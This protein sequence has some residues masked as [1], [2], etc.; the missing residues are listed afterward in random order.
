MWSILSRRAALAAA[1]LFVSLVL[2][3]PVFAQG[4]VQLPRTVFDLDESYGDNGKLD[5]KGEK[6][7]GISS[8]DLPGGQQGILL[9]LPESYLLARYEL[10]AVAS[11]PQ[12]IMGRFGKKVRCRVDW[13][14]TNTSPGPLQPQITG[15]QSGIPELDQAIAA[16]LPLA[17]G[18]AAAAHQER[19]HNK[20]CKLRMHKIPG[21]VFNPQTPDLTI[22]ELAD[23][24][25][26]DCLTLDRP[27]A[28]LLV[29]YFEVDLDNP[30]GVNTL[31]SV[32][33]ADEGCTLTRVTLWTDLAVPTLS[34]YLYLSPNDVQTL[35]LRDLFN[36]HLPDT[37]S[38]LGDLSCP[39]LDFDPCT[40]AQ[41]DTE[42]V[43]LEL[44]SLAAA[45]RGAADPQSGTC[46]SVDHGDRL[47]RGYLTADV[48]ERC[49]HDPTVATWSVSE[50]QAP[51]GYHAATATGTRNALWGDYFLV[52]EAN[53][54]AQSEAAVPV[55]A[56]PGRFEPGDYTFYG[57]Y[58]GFDGSDAHRPLSG[59]QGIRFLQGG[60]FDGGTELL[61]WRD[62]RSPEVAPVA[63]GELPDWAPLAQ[64][65]IGLFDED[66]L[67]YQAP[68]GSVFPWATQ[69]VAVGG[70]DFPSPVPFGWL[71]L[72][73]WHDPETPAQAWVTAVV[74]ARGRFSVQHRAT[75]LDDLCA[76]PATA[77]EAP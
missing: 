20:S 40:A 62:T 39:V 53:D 27:A 9:V 69:R 31:A 21:V 1:V 54:F 18:K 63:C 17:P 47:V 5:E 15:F 7:V 66:E 2:T 48:V 3:P 49:T 10:R 45:H 74:S 4:W 65:H 28:T 8:T 30:L 36:G 73:L 24:D 6:V 46:A 51:E 29:P 34:F 59:R 71:D 67:P 37:S 43:H 50:W 38:V 35:N 57:R 22:V 52:D 12:V 75:P 72:D 61:V 64:R 16:A 14:L 41:L 68:T 76:Q 23:D 70:S 19:I 58:D 32:A 25:L 60:P 42:L 55:I 11:V 13:T 56:D 77:L 44:Q 26:D 33:N